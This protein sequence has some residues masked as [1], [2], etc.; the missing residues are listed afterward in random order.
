MRSGQLDVSSRG[1]SENPVKRIL[2][3]RPLRLVIN[4]SVSLYAFITLLL[5][6]IYAYRAENSFSTGYPGDRCLPMFDRVK[7]SLT[8]AQLNSPTT[9]TNVLYSY[10]IG[11]S[12]LRVCS[13]VSAAIVNDQFRANQYDP[14]RAANGCDMSN[15]S[16][17]AQ[18]SQYCL[19]SSGNRLNCT[20]VLLTLPLSNGDP[21]SINKNKTG[22]PQGH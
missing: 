21:Y 15:P 3:G 7:A 18:A 17:F 12:Q 20:D 19:D 13:N 10:S 8:N 4:G 6:I 22:I 9:A 14:M 2:T 5:N 11:N 1:M 16:H